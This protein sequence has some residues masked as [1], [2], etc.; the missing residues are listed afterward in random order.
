MI[1]ID[2]PLKILVS[3]NEVGDAWVYHNDPSW[4]AA[5]ACA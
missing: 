4:L 2:I 5:A 1:G 3:Q